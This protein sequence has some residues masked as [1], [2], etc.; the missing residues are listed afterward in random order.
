[1][2]RALLGFRRLGFR[3]WDYGPVLS[4][5]DPQMEVARLT[6]VKLGWGLR[7]RPW[8]ATK[9]KAH[10][11]S[12]SHGS[13]TGGRDTGPGMAKVTQLNVQP[14]VHPVFESHPLGRHPR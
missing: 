2:V 10:Q 12:S 14:V 4:V 6:W 8:N 9:S 1:M 3:C 11:Q 13:T 5:N 7:I